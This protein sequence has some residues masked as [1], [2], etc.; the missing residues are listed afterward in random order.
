MLVARDFTVR[1]RYGVVSIFDSGGSVLRSY[2]V[3]SDE[4]LA[5]RLK[6]AGAPSGCVPSVWEA[7]LA[8]VDGYDLSPGE[9]RL[10]PS[11][12]LELCVAEWTIGQRT[13]TTTIVFEPEE[14]TGVPPAVTVPRRVLDDLRAQGTAVVVPVSITDGV[15]VLP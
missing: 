10:G 11:G 3:T 5:L 1:D 14:F 15:M 4:L 13:G 2:V 12:G 6:G 8:R 9:I 7:G